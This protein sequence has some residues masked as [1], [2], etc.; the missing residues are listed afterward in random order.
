MPCSIA[1]AKV[2][3]PFYCQRTAIWSLAARATRTD[4]GRAAV[5]SSV[6]RTPPSNS[7]PERRSSRFSESQAWSAS[8]SLQRQRVYRCARHRVRT[9]IF[10][11]FSKSTRRFFPGTDMCIV[12]AGYIFC[13]FCI[14]PCT[15]G[16]LPWCQQTCT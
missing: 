16:C 11:P 4:L 6:Q 2:A 12:R 14:P 3:L 13:I 7:F 5:N 10:A 9:A 8:T 15:V 1:K